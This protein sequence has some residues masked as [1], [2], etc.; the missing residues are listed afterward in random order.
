M[1]GLSPEIARDLAALRR[2]RPLVHCL[3]HSPARMFIANALLAA[4]ASPAM[5]V[6]EEEVGPF[7]ASARAVLINL[8]S[9]SP[10]VAA[11]MRA[12]VAAAGAAGTP[13]VLDPAAI[14][15]VLAPRTALARELLAARPAILKGNASEILTLSGAEGGGL[16]PDAT[17]SVATAL[18]AAQALAR[19]SGAVVAVTGPVDLVTD[20]DA[21]L[22]IPG[23]DALMPVIT[24]TGCAL[25]GLMAALLGANVPPL[26]AA[27]SACTTFARAAEVAAREASGPGSF[28]VAFID[29]LYGMGRS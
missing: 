7:A 24:G 10:P 25:G 17:A 11:A 9:V 4:G 18:P 13:V 19:A 16:G 1:P 20:G 29:A 28:S 12:S 8:G 21:V 23:G 15:G 22:E 6:A 26:R 27:I 3:T 2:A 5:V 14:G